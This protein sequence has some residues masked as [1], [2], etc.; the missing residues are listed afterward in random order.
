MALKPSSAVYSVSKHKKFVMCLMEKICV[1]DM[2][3]F[4]HEIVSL[5]KSSM[6]MNQQNIL[7]KESLSTSIHKTKLYMIS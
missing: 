7:N 6:L 3:T 5:T 1:L 4:R 2:P